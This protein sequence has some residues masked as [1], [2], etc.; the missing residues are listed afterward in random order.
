MIDVRSWCVRLARLGTRVLAALGLLFLIVSLTPVDNWWATILAG[1]AYTETGEVLVV[2]SGSV[3][4]DESMGWSSYLRATYA[5]RAFRDGGFKE[6]LI[7]GGPAGQ[8]KVPVSIAMGEFLKFQGIPSG[9]IHLET[10]SRSTRENA[11]CSSAL[12][13]TLPD[14]KVLLTSDYHMFRARHAFA[15]V[16]IQVFPQPVP[17]VIKRSGQ[18]WMRWPAF[19]D[20]LRETVK[21]GYYW[22]RRWI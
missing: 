11:L 14:R 1:Q 21:I 22:V 2:L 5:G 6:V 13:N 16:G 20:L 3:A 18:W 8:S 17:D 7:A 15:R 4:D 10:R 12:L 19:L 9:A